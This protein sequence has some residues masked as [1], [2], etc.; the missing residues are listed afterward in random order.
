[1]SLES[2]SQSVVW[3]N[4]NLIIPA[5]TFAIPLAIE[6]ILFC[7]KLYKD[8]D[9]INRT[10]KELKESVCDAFQKR[11]GEPEIDFLQRRN[12][13]IAITVI[14]L[15]LIAGAT[16]NAFIFLPTGYA[17]PAA[18]AALYV[19]GKLSLMYQRNPDAMKKL[20][21]YL[22]DTF[23]PKGD[24]SQ[25]DFQVRKKQHIKQIALYSL[26]GVVAAGALTAIVLFSL[27]AAKAKS[28]W[29]TNHILPFQT[30]GV[31]IAEYLSVGAAHAFLAAKHWKKGDR[32]RAVSHAVAVFFSIFFPMLYKFAPGYE[33]RLHHS[34][35]G[36]ALQLAP[37]RAMRSVGAAIMLDSLLYCFA[38]NRGFFAPGSNFMT[39]YDIMNALYDN[40][41]FVCQA[42]VGMTLLE[43]AMECL[44]VKSDNSDPKDKKHAH[45]LALSK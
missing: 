10:C 4:S 40:L 11:D 37:S 38:S 18:L 20:L 22:Q 45:T 13:N 28:I 41:P 12:R 6:T 29:D 26:M 34:F 30:S 24:E 32:A 14:A 44:K 15:C 36:L 3:E 39:N 33:M 5:V 16:T 17:I 1:M 9:I 7:R 8:P 21:S 27:K 42:L 35:I 19:I 25:E 2:F 23:S 43:K 31:V